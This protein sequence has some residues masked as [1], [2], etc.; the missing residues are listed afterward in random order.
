MQTRTDLL[1]LPFPDP[2]SLP[3]FCVL[4]QG[5]HPKKNDW[6]DVNPKKQC[7]C[8]NGLPRVNEG[9]HRLTVAPHMLCTWGW[10]SDWAL[11]FSRYAWLLTLSESTTVVK[12]RYHLSTSGLTLPHPIQAMQIISSFA[13]MLTS[14]ICTTWAYQNCTIWK[15][16]YHQMD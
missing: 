15:P 16:N 13:T 1:P 9:P 4:V 6:F 14:Q 5:V 2:A 11:S 12:P 10:T 8:W 7:I 3:V